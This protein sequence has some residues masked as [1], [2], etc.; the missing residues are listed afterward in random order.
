MTMATQLPQVL[1]D[2]I[3]KYRAPATGEELEMG[4]IA[5]PDQHCLLSTALGDLGRLAM[6]TNVVTGPLV[7]VL[8]HCDGEG[9]LRQRAL[10][11]GWLTDVA[12]RLSQ[13]DADLELLEREFG[14]DFSKLMH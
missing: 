6:M 11:A 5:H 2:L 3:A 12:M 14:A 9:A 4:E 10:V 13:A 7:Q 1:V 8:R